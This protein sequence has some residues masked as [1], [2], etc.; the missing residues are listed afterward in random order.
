MRAACLTVRNPFDP[1]GSRSW[2]PVRRRARVRALAPRTRSPFIAQLNGRPILRAEWRRKLNHGDVLVFV[3]L[4]QGGGGGGSNPL[5]T[6]LSLALVAFAGPLAGLLLGPSLAGTALFGTFTVGQAASL[7]L[8]LA[9]QALINAVLPPPQVPERAALPTPARTY[10]LAAQGNTAR[11]EQAIPVQYGRVLSYPDFAAQP[12]TEFAGGEQYLFQLLCLG[13]GEFEIEDIRLEDSSLDAFTEIEYEIVEPFGQVT[14]FPTQVVTSVEVSSQSFDTWKGLD[15]SQSGTTVTVT[16]IGHNRAI[17]QA[18][19][20]ADTYQEIIGKYEIVRTTADSWT[21]DAPVTGNYD[22]GASGPAYVEGVSLTWTAAGTEFTFAEIGHARSEGDIVVMGGGPNAGTYPIASTPDADSWTFEIAASATDTGISYFYNVL[23]AGDGFVASAAGTV[24]GRLGID[25]VAPRGV[26]W[27]DGGG[28]YR[29]HAFLV[30]IQARPLDDDGAPTGAWFDLGQEFIADRTTTPVRL[31]FQYLLDTPGRYAVRARCEHAPYKNGLGDE[32]LLS[33]LR[34]YLQ[35]EPEASP[36]TLIALRMRATNNLS[37][38]ASRKFGVVATRRIPVWT[39]S[40][41]SAPQ[42]TRSIAWA[43]ADAARSEVYGAGWADSRIDTAALAA[44]DAVWEARGDFFDGRFTDAATWWESVSQI[45]RAGRARPYLQGGKLRVVR[46]GA[47]TLPVALYSMRNIL[48]DSFSID[49]LMPDDATADAVEVSY[50][51]AA[52]WT[53]RKVTAK[54]P[55]S[56]AARPVK[57]ELFGVTSRAHAL[58]EG[59]YEA[60][61]NRYRRRI[62]HLA[63]EMEGFIPSVGDLIAVQHDMPGWAA[64]AE[65]VA[66]DAETRTLT[67]TEPLTFAEGPHF[68]GLRKADGG[69]SGP[70]EVRPGPTPREVILTDPPDITPLTGTDRERTH[71]TFGASTRWRVLAK[72]LEARPRDLHSVEIDFVVED[73]SVH[74]AEDGAVAPP[75]V[76]GSLPVRRTFP[77]VA[78]LFARRSIDDPT[79]AQLGWTPAPGADLYQIELAEGTDPAEAGLSW[80]RVADTTSSSYLVML[81]YADR[82]LIR[83]RGVGAAAGPWIYESLGDALA[84]FW[85]DDSLVVWSDDTAEIWS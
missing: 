40:D 1:L 20:F 9:G 58:R 60:A 53:P 30:V 3:V 6:L 21:I 59:L 72:V 22:A 54:L 31:S 15:W 38:Q 10:S 45:A 42:A 7:G 52:T 12:Y 74:T 70:W 68:V 62:G 55:D 80:T 44:L 48:R 39:G 26:F 36:V 73:P 33:G 46:D 17:G 23:G 24:A 78:G 81:L 85:S 41:W 79:R 75:L 16:E 34:A 49:Y 43:I 84:P 11:I 14:L 71:V 18:V 77:V 69:L 37:L 19:H 83:V 28:G 61:A 47:E 56:T 27:A 51:D 4:P 2:H 5:R 32:V 29:T 63:T 82:T 67:L 8:V 76:I 66:W 13:C 57:M 64:Q 50:M 65:A 25:I 35:R